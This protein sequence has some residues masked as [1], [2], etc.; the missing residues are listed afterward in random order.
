MEQ[1]NKDVKMAFGVMGVILALALLA[2]LLG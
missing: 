2:T 1:G